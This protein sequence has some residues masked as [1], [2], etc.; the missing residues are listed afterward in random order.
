[1]DR[2]DNSALFSEDDVVEVFIR[3][4]PGGTR[5]ENGAGGKWDTPP[6]DWFADKTEDYLDLHLIPK[7]PGL[8]KLDRFE[9]FIDARK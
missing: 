6:E 4:N 9:D 1:M 7:D 2:I 8:W 3:E 5:Q